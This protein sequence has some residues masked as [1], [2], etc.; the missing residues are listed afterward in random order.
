MVRSE[1]FAKIQFGASAS[2][3]IKFQNKRARASVFIMG[4]TLETNQLI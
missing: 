1:T 2:S 4:S 3:A